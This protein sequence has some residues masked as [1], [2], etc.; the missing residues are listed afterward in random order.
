MERK[1]IVLRIR[2]N[3]AHRT[4]FLFADISLEVEGID[5]LVLLIEK[6]DR[7]W[8]KHAQK[9]GFARQRRPCLAQ[10]FQHI[11]HSK[12][13]FAQ[14][15]ESVGPFEDLLRQPSFD[16]EDAFDFLSGGRKLSQGQKIFVHL[17][18]PL[19]RNPACQKFRRRKA[20]SSS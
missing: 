20:R 18:I 4:I 14:E 11:A 10:H 3:P 13:E 6:S 5:L 7:I 1:W 12:I 8:V 16:M 19:A 17:I 9:D 15:L 2:L